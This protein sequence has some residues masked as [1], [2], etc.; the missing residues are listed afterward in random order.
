MQK[1]TRTETKYMR[2]AKENTENNTEEK[3]K[4][5]KIKVHFM[6][7]YTPTSYCVKIFTKMF[8]VLIIK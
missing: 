8:I 5:E 2:Q 1:E 6:V 4:K 3:R 7:I